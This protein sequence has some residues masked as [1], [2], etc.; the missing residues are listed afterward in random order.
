MS[1]DKIECDTHGQAFT[2]FVCQHLV[3][4]EGLEWHST[5]PDEE[6]PWPDAWCGECNAAFE[7]EGEWN[8]KS[9][10]E[11]RI[12][13]VCHRCYESTKARCTVHYV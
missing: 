3:G 5:E 10:S 6:N 1:T 12:K 13:I 9:E 11:V 8:E 7:R 2:T 4:G